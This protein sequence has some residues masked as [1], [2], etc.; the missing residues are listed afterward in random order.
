MAEAIGY[1]KVVI[2]SSDKDMFQVPTLHY[3]PYKIQ[4]KNQPKI[5]RWFNSEKFAANRFFRLQVLAGDSTDMPN[6]LCGI[7]GIGMGK[8]IGEEGKAGK[9]LDKPEY[10]D[11]GFEKIIQLEYTKKY[12]AKE[13][14]KR[15]NVTYKMVRLLKLDHNGYIN[16]KARTE[17]ATILATYDSYTQ[18]PVSATDQLFGGSTANDVVNLFK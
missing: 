9:A 5:E 14:F 11:L 1:D 8:K 18:K 13:G 17:L 16:I 2:V 3:N 4:P 6:A 12:G 15:A 10:D 7:Q